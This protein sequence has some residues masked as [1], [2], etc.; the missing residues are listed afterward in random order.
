MRIYR[1]AHALNQTQ[2]GRKIGATCDHVSRVERGVGQLTEKQAKKLAALF[3]QSALE[4]M[5]KA[6]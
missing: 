3:E 4:D 6:S 1:A 5:V 2:L